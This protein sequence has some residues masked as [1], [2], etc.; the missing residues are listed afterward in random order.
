M[1]NLRKSSKGLFDLPSIMVGIVITAIIG[2]AAAATFLV[3]V[4]WLQDNQAKDVLTSISV[5]ET[6]ARQDLG[7][8]TDYTTLQKNGWLVKQKLKTCVTA[9]TTSYQAF[10]VAQNGNMFRLD[11]N[12][13]TPEEWSDGATCTLA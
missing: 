9:T 4:P 7:K 3:V 6:T 1:K 12:N 11:S 8:Y 13:G 2:L 10:V 5:A